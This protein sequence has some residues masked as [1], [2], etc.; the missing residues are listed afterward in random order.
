MP[1]LRHDRRFPLFAERAQAAGLAAVFAFPL[2]HGE[3]RLGAL[4]L[5]RDTPGAL[6]KGDMHAAET[7]ADVAAAYLLNAQARTELQASRDQSRSSAVH[8]ALT[9]LPNRTL[10]LERLEH[11]VER[12]RRSGR[13][14]GILFADLDGF[15]AINDHYGHGAGDELLIGVAERLSLLL[16]PGDTLAR[17]SG[18]EFV[19]LCED[20]VDPMEADAIAERLVD[21][22]ATPFALTEAEVQIS[23]SVGIALARGEGGR[24]DELLRAADTAMYQAKRKGGG[25]CCPSGWRGPCSAARESV[26]AADTATAGAQVRAP[27]TSRSG[28]LGCGGCVRRRPRGQ[29][30]A[31]PL[32]RFRPVRC[33]VRRRHGVG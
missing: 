12:S 1:D 18:D 17:L 15:K 16:R 22:V 23:A 26:M 5:Y 9:G 24:G 10:L 11:A 2:Y 3:G 7:L 20:L 21:A 27:I 8:D 6:G 19:I 31:P 4:D 30:V 14:T 32:G 28:Q 33:A 13:F 29:S 25:R